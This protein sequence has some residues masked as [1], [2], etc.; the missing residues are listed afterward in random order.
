MVSPRQLEE[1]RRI[2]SRGRL[3]LGELLINMQ[4]CKQEDIDRVLGTQYNMR[5]EVESA[6]KKFG[7]I[8]VQHQVVSPRKVEEAAEIQQMS[9]QKM[10]LTLLNLGTCSEDDFNDALELQF[11]WRRAKDESRDRL[12]LE[13]LNKGE[14]SQP[15]L[16]NALAIHAKA[17]KPLGQILVE[18]GSCPPESVID[19]LITREER[20]RENFFQ[21]ITENA[22]IAPA[23]AAQAPAPP[24]GG[25]AQT[26]ESKGSASVVQKISSW[27]KKP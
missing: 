20:R 9:R 8:L 21:F 27:F 12:G 2:Q 19:T 3:M 16:E 11:S 24:A 14:V 15:N 10:G 22:Q 17:G 6:P 5:R 23:H 1:A 25:D 18:T 4:K 26:Q 13:L 7:E